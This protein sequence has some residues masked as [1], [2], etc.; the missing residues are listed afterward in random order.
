MM[1]DL[2]IVKDT[3]NPLSNIL[4]KSTKYKELVAM[5]QFFNDQKKSY[6]GRAKKQYPF[7]YQLIKVQI[8]IAGLGSEF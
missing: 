8:T 6:Y 5:D 4:T 2:Y 3:N 7:A 1:K